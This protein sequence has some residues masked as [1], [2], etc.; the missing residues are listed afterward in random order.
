MPDRPHILILMPD[1]MRADCLGCAGHPVIRTPNLDRLAREGVRFTEATTV[2]PICMPAR[3]SF[4]SGRYVHNHGMW[5]N[6]GQLPADDLSVFHILRRGGYHTAHIGKAHYYVHEAHHLREERAPELNHMRAHEDYLRARGFETVHET[7]GPWA[8]CFMQ[9]YM[10]DWWEERGL[11][12]AFKQDYAERSRAR[13]SRDSP[14]HLTHPS[15]L[16]TEDYPDSYVGRRAVEFVQ[17]YEDSR[18][19]CL[20]V[21]FPSPHEPW[22]APGDYAHRYDP[23]AMPD[24]IPAPERG[25][26]LPDAV[27]DREDF[28]NTR[29]VDLESAR[30]I[31]ASYYGKISLVDRW[32][33]QI[34]KAY[35]DRGWLDD[36]CVVFWSDHGEMAG[37]H[38]RL[39]KQT[40]HESSVRVPFILRCPSGVPAGVTSDALV[41]T[42]DLPATL[43]D[44]AGLAPS[45]RILG[46]SLLSHLEPGVPSRDCQI[47]EI[48]YGGSRNT[49]LRTRTHKYAVDER[50]TGYMLYDLAT[51]P[52]EQQNLVGRPEAESLERGLRE[53][54]FR[55]ILESQD[56]M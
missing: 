32:V 46:T 18:P 41:E 43:L 16:P 53:R 8:T 54:L 26:E 20:F 47:S 33:G 24:P 40:F 22:D 36:L 29:G 42:V 50:G 14:A 35:E 38:G 9:S 1:Q 48:A 39:Y 27:R 49:M 15:P 11:Y 37:D 3:A 31:R 7:T 51:D 19:M 21:G 30:A 17:S 6:S 56:C 13:T 2:S 4:I 45:R 55:R 28:R 12:D 34:V 44:L 10:T 52:D 5:A 23:E 25:T